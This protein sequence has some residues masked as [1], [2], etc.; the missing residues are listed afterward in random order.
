[1]LYKVLLARVLLTFLN[2]EDFIVLRGDR[3][4]FFKNRK[5]TNWQLLIYISLTL[6]R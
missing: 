6:C 1:M 3:D 2:S 5:Q 4:I